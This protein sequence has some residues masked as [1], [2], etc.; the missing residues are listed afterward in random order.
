MEELQQPQ[1]VRDNR[2]L[3]RRYHREVWEAG[4]LD[5]I[6]R[7]IG[8]GFVS[9]APQRGDLAQLRAALPDM[10][11]REDAI[12]GAGDRVIIQ[13]TI[14]ATHTGAA[15]FDLPAQGRT[16]QVSGIDVLRVD[17]NLF[18]EHWG[19]ISDQRAEIIRQ[20]SQK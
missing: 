15:L 3:L 11:S 7:F 12:W 9:H 18:V 8:P 14:K 4:R 1:A 17:N 20:L 13:W 5:A 10:T 16:V 6:P 2:E 19:G